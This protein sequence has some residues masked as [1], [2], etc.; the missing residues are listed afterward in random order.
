MAEEWGGRRAL[1]DAIDE[2]LLEQ[3]AETVERKPRPDK[4]AKRRLT[5]EQ[6]EAMASGLEEYDGKIQGGRLVGG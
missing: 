5:K 1:E 2:F 4:L 6:A 3:E